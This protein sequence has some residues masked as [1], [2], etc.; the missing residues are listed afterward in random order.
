MT[1]NTCI[2]SAGMV[3]LL[4]ACMIPM[5][6]AS[7]T[8]QPGYINVGLTP[9]VQFD[10]HYA[11][12]TVPTNVIF[13]DNSLGSTPLTY[14]W[15]FGDGATSTEPNPLHIYTTRGIFTVKLTV[16]NAYG[17][18]TEIKNNFISIGME[19]AAAFTATPENGKVPMAVKFIDRSEGQVESWQWSFG[20]GERSTEKDPVHTYLTAGVYNVILTVSNEYGS[21]DTTKPGFI[22]VVGPLLSKFTADP[23]SGSAPVTVKFTDH[24][25]G[26]PTSWKW[27]FGDGGTSTEQN[28][29]H[30]FTNGNAFEVKLEIER[31]GDT[32]DSTQVVN[33]G[34]VPL[35]DFTVDQRTGNAPF[36]VQFK[37]ISTGNPTKWNWQF[38]DG[39]SSSDQNPQHLYPWA[40]AYDVILTVSNEYGSDTIY[41]NGSAVETIVP[42]V[43]QK[44]VVTKAP[45]V[46]KTTAKAVAPRNTTTKASLSPTIT[47]SG[48]LI[49]LIAIA[50]AH[51]K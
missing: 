10:A 45:T 18:S 8:S 9:V 19:P 37:D 36:I 26:N 24:S 48:S 15:D 41:R 43:R 16:T 4:F 17:S 30:T 20:D 12:A 27:N 13:V 38:G 50:I 31:A 49:G 22:T 51:R 46:V 11:F 1:H 29:T 33:F 40:G 6:T 32:A 23:T 3:F 39:T 14:Q 2:V 28:P 47:V 5:A 44:L 35:A 34:E 7:G 21:S 42:A 25:I